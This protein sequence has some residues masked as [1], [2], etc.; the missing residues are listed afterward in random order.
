[1]TV[2]AYGATRPLRNLAI[3]AL[4]LLATPALAEVKILAFGDS[5]TAGYG[6][7][8]EQGFVPR[9]QAWL[10]AHGAP[11]V[12]VINEIGRASCR[13]RVSSPV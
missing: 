13:E 3:V 11:D 4:T 8:A 7:P 2:F 6:L 1:M 10:A 9:L 12:T 5:L